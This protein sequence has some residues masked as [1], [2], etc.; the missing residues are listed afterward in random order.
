MIFLLQGR[1]LRGREETRQPAAT[2]A[3]SQ[4]FPNLS[5]C[6]PKTGA[7]APENRMS[8]SAPTLRSERL[9]MSP[10]G[11]GDREPLRAL[12]S[13]E[14]VYRYLL[15]GS[16]PQAAWVASI[17]ADS[18]DGFARRGLGLWAARRPGD[19]AL[20][21][22]VGFRDF[23]DPP[24]EGLIYALHPDLWGRGV[25]SEMA[26]AAVDHAFTAA[27]RERV[28]ASTDLP[29]RDSLAVMRRLGMRETGREPAPPGSRREQV[30]C[31]IERS[32]WECQLRHP[33]REGT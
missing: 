1:D 33:G 21:G 22:L 12:L 9:E 10:I 6:R 28:R 11:D 30:H 19:P 31:E 8:A 18:R 29:N 3:K 15:D 14:P 13:L 26:R 23:Y 5:A 27:G 2:G 4:A 17:V 7:E 32:A 16:P 20:I 24:V 25:A